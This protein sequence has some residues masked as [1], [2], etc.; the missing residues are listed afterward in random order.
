METAS[1]AA[2][3]AAITV[4][5]N[6]QPTA[7]GGEYNHNSFMAAVTAAR[8]AAKHA[9]LS[10]ADSGGASDNVATA[11]AVIVGD[12]ADVAV[13]DAPADVGGT[14]GV[15]D[16]FGDAV[17]A[18]IGNDV[19]IDAD[20]A[21]SSGDAVGDADCNA[22]ADAVVNSVDAIVAD[23]AAGGIEKSMHSMGVGR[24]M[25]A[26]YTGMDAPQ[27]PPLCEARQKPAGPHEATEVGR[28][29]DRLGLCRYQMTFYVAEIY[30]LRELS[31][32]TTDRLMVR[33]PVSVFEF[34]ERSRF[35]DLCFFV[36]RT[37]RA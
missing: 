34:H 21:R 9:V 37:C 4:L 28:Y 24:N 1:T 7:E 16:V 30:L 19:G 33:T 36:F 35:C 29:L 10:L 18:A 23:D 3:H 12:A 14:V 25:S 11:S 13:D 27:E 22:D 5:L 20:A 17:T 26:P 32:W 31:Y 2:A 15:S 8:A 6:E